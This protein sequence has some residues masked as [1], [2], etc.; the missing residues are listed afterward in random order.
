MNQLHLCTQESILNVFK[1]VHSNRE[2]PVNEISEKVE[3]VA[4]AL[5]LLLCIQIV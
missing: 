5:L 3:W 2:A 4:L 1:A